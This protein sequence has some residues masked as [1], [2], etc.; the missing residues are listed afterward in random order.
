MTAV[1]RPCLTWRP[2]RRVPR[3]EPP[4]SGGVG[5]GDVTQADDDGN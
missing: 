3:I 4:N 2:D 5:G 1:L